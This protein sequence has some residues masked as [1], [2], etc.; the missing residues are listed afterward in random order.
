MQLGDQNEHLV[1]GRCT[2]TGRVR[3]SEYSRIE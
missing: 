2:G 3:G 1:G